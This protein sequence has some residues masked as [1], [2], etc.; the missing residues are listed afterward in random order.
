[1]TMLM[2]ENPNTFEMS[3]IFSEDVQ[4]GELREDLHQARYEARPARAAA[5]RRTRRERLA[6]EAWQ[7]FAERQARRRE[8]DRLAAALRQRLSA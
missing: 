1:M 8:P 2:N 4:T 7:R 6:E 5:D 3:V